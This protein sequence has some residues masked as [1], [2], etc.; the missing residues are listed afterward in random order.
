MNDMTRTAVRIAAGAA[1]TY[2]TGRVVKELRL[3]AAATPIVSIVVGGLVDRAVR[4][5]P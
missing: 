2:L 3:P 1:T 5:L 4:R